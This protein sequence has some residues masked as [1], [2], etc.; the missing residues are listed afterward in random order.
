MHHSRLHNIRYTNGLYA[1]NL[2]EIVEIYDEFHQLLTLVRIDPWAQHRLQTWN[3]VSK[4]TNSVFVLT[5]FLRVESYAN[6][7][8]QLNLLPSS[9]DVELTF[10][11]FNIGTYW[12][13]RRRS[14]KEQ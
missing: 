4:A 2:F 9:P 10:K 1:K 13:I 11:Y 8:Q 5:I 3:Y 14:F 7:I 12:K 6:W